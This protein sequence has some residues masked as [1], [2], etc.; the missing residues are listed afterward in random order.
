MILKLEL[1]SLKVEFETMIIKADFNGTL[2][3]ESS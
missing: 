2:S 1:I 3:C